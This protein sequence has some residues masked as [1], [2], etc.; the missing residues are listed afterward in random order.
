MAEHSDERLIR[1]PTVPSRMTFNVRFRTRDTGSTARVYPGV[2]DGIAASQ[3]NRLEILRHNLGRNTKYL[4]VISSLSSITPITYLSALSIKRPEH[5]DTPHQCG[6]NGIIEVMKAINKLISYRKIHFFKPVKH[7]MA[8]NT[9]GQEKLVCER[10]IQKLVNVGEL[11]LVVSYFS[12]DLNKHQGLLSPFA[13]FLSLLLIGSKL[14][15][16]VAGVVSCDSQAISEYAQY[17]RGNYCTNRTNRRNRIPP[18]HTVSDTQLFAAENTTPST[19]FMSSLLSAR[20][21]ATASR[22]SEAAHG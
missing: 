1:S 19:H 17:D 16:S 22:Q 9:I 20:H 2:D 15:R 4:I 11:L 13:R 14:H 21:S 12:V 5:C 8:E 3:T 6:S 7:R 18:H 10:A